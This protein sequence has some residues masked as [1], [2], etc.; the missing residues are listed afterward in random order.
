MLTVREIITLAWTA[1]GNTG[2]P[3]REFILRWR[4]ENIEYGRCPLTA[5]FRSGSTMRIKPAAFEEPD[6]DELATMP[7]VVLARQIEIERGRV[8]WLSDPHAGRPFG[9]RPATPE[10]IA[11][12]R[13]R[14]AELEAE[15][16]RR[17]Q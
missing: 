10:Q 17:D 4:T 6:P 15:L 11:S 1:A 16:Q 7:A 5:R 2:D 8:E 9:D 13:E 12:A 14:V 3:S